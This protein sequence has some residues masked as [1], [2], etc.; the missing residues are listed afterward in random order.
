M[1]EEKTGP[2]LFST[3]VPGDMDIKEWAAGGFS[4]FLHPE[5]DC[6]KEI[7]SA[8]EKFK[9]SLLADIDLIVETNEDY[10]FLMIEEIENF[11]KNY[12]P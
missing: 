11:I 6:T 2:R 3:V 9:K 12:K 10:N 4:K 5:K 1:N 7:N 8:I